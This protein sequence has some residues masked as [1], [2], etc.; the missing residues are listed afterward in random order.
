M[1]SSFFVMKDTTFY[2]KL[3]YHENIK[4]YKDVNNKLGDSR[5]ELAVTKVVNMEDKW[6]NLVVFAVTSYLVTKYILTRG[7]LW[8]N[9]FLAAV[10]L[11]ECFLLLILTRQNDLAVRQVK[12]YR[13]RCSSGVIFVV[14]VP[15]AL[16]G[17]SG[18]LGISNSSQDHETMFEMVWLSLSLSIVL[19]TKYFSEARVLCGLLPCF[20]ILGFALPWIFSTPRQAVLMGIFNVIVWRGMDLI[21]SALPKS[22]TFGELA[23]VLQLIVSWACRLVSGVSEVYEIDEDDLKLM[24][25]INTVL[26]SVSTATLIVCLSGSYSSLVATSAVYVCHAGIS[27]VFLH[28]QIREQPLLWL[29]GYI[30]KSCPRVMLLV[31]FILMLAFALIWTTV[32]GLQSQV[33]LRQSKPC[34]SDTPQMNSKT[35]K[36]TRRNGN[37]LL[38][39]VDEP[40]QESSR[41]IKGL[42]S[43]M[44]ARRNNLIETRKIFHLFI[45]LVYVPGLLLDPTFLLLS[46]GCVF[47][48]FIIL[49]A[50][51]ALQVPL[52][53]K[54]L[55]DVQRSFVDERDQGVVFLTHIYL[56]AGLSLPLWISP[57]VLTADLAPLELYSGVLALGIGDTI[58]CIAGR[59]FGRIRWPGL[60]TVESYTS[61]TVGIV[62]SGLVEA[63]TDQIDNLILPLVLY[64]FLCS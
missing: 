48:V 47:G 41:T 1:T 51:R 21:P 37:D 10:F 6:N 2:L 46:S 38:R 34:D 28:S 20:L 24:W 64:P 14:L 35:D 17:T 43:N 12:N 18:A 63:F 15:L 42:D 60:L 50:S 49:E 19:V 30:F 44:E 26:I 55:D 53:G 9:I 29:I 32:Q 61:V 16:L 5:R 54:L 13:P 36:S 56:L 25:F 11:T 62:L 59:A 58:A 40:S 45:L 7:M 52:I 27:L 33:Q 3:F 23:V 22:F 4:I 8:E 57:N 39:E 31:I